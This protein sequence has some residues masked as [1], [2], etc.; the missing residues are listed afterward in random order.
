MRNQTSDHDMATEA[1]CTTEHLSIMRKHF[2]P[3]RTKVQFRYKPRKVTIH[4]FILIFTKSSNSLKLLYNISDVK[5]FTEN[6]K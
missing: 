1:S 3:E 6:D 2:A 4:V 5:Q